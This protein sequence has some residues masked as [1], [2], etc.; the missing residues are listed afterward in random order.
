VLGCCLQA[1]QCCS[2]GESAPPAD[3][4]HLLSGV[5]L[6]VDMVIR[7]LVLSVQPANWW[8]GC[9][10][11]G[12]GRIQTFVL[13]CCARGN[14]KLPVAVAPPVGDSGWNQCGEQSGPCSELCPMLKK[15]TASVIFMGSHGHDSTAEAHSMHDGH[16]HVCGGPL[17]LS[18]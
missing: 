17:E 6:C 18:V 10:M 4:L 9:H 12:S 16:C 11:N 7:H 8:A 13:H 14:H 5:M 1:A 3:L 15:D 2:R